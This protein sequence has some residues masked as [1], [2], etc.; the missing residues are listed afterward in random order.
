MA[1]ALSFTALQHTVFF[2]I[3]YKNSFCS[4]EFVGSVRGV[5][6]DS[7]FV[8]CYGLSIRRKIRDGLNLELLQLLPSSS[9]FL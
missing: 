4:S 7:S 2:Q 8:G 1:C 5:A 9:H 3:L 6:E